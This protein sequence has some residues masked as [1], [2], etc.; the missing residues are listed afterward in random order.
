MHHFPEMKIPEAIATHT[1]YFTSARKCKMCKMDR[2]RW[3]SAWT[4]SGVECYTC[5]P[6]VHHTSKAKTE[7]R[8]RSVKQP[9]PW[10]SPLPRV[11]SG[12]NTR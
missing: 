9:G 3:L 10:D 4:A 11:F 8:K 7:P 1:K 12:Y 2:R 5:V 6:D